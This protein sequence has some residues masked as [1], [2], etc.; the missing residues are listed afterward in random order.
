MPINAI[1]IPVDLLEKIIELAKKK[2]RKEEIAG[3]FLGKIEDGVAKV[4]ECKEGEN[5]YHNP[6]RFMIHPEELYKIIVEGEEKGLE[7]VGVW[8]TH[9]GD[10]NPSIIDVKSM[11]LWPVVWI[12]FDAITGIFTASIY[13]PETERIKNV[14]VELVK[15]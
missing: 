6:S 15:K 10:P 12:I 2:G 14:K 8:H 13:D 4:V 7:V 5:I 1:N 11:M 3:I 9:I